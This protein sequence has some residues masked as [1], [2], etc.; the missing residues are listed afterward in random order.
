MRF[1][2]A[3]VL[4][5]ALAGALGPARAE[6]EPA[7]EALA[8]GQEIVVPTAPALDA[9]FREML[10]PLMARLPAAERSVMQKSLD[11][12]WPG[13]RNDILAE[14]AKMYARTLTVSELRE[15]AEFQKTPAW[16]KSM[17]LAT[18]MHPEFKSMVTQKVARMMM[19]A[20][21]AVRAFRASAPK[22]K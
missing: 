22:A 12:S 1:I 15:V 18:G 17:Q 9:M 6:T 4:A 10:T 20:D 14:T 3:V 16:Q 19:D 7:A 8:L 21:A 13:V 2:H 5:I 11:T